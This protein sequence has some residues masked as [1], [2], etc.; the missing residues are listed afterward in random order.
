[1]HSEIGCNTQQYGKEE[2]SHWSG[3]EPTD[4]DEEMHGEFIVDLEETLEVMFS[5]DGIIQR[6]KKE[7]MRKYKKSRKNR[8]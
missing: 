5:F 7:T 6:G 2:R 4:Q 8:A 1:L 3:S